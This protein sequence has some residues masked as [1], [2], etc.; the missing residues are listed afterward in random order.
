MRLE[1]CEAEFVFVEKHFFEIKDA[2][3]DSGYD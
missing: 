3:G 2:E 1:Q